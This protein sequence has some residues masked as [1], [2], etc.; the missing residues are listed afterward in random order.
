[1]KFALRLTSLGIVFIAMFTIVGLRL[2]FVQVAEGP[3]YAQAAEELTWIPRGSY[4]PRGDIYDRNGTL[5]ATSRLVPAVVVDRTFVQPDERE[6]L[7]Q[8]LAALL[9]LDPTAL[10]ALYEE[11]GINGRFQVTTV[12]SD[13]AFRINERL[14]MLPGVEIVSVPERVYLAGPTLAHVIGHLGRPDEA[15]LEDRPDLDPSVRIGKLGVERIYDEF[16][17]GTPG[18]V[19]Y[20][21][22]RLVS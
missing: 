21:A 22:R 18:Q 4:A 8:N 20:R 16:L 1:M 2:W 14:D 6:L 3:A 10:D 12:S 13:T 9:G 7:I 19:E 15:D 11:A 5:L 17:Q